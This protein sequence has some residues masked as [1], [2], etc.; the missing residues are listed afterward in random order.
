MA[1][2]AIAGGTGGVGRTILEELIRQK[3]H[4]VVVLSRKVCLSNAAQLTAYRS[5][6]RTQDTQIKGYESV[7]VLA[8]DYSDVDSTAA[9]LQK[10]NIGTIISALSLFTEEVGEAQMRL[11]QAAINSNVVKRFV[12]SEFAFNYLR[13]GLRDFHDAAQMRMDAAD[14]L[15]DSHVEFTRFVFGWILD[16]WNPVSAKTNMPPMTWVVDFPN[17]KARI[18]GDGTKSITVMH[19]HDIGKYIAALL[20]EEKA[21][22]EMSAFAGDKVS[23]NEMV[24]MAER[25]TGMMVPA[26]NTIEVADA[27]M[28]GQKFEV[29]FEPIERLEKKE[30]EVLEQPEGSYDFGEGL[31]QVT[32]E[33]GLMVVK[34]MMDASIDGLRNDEFPGVKPIKMEAWMR[35]VWG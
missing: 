13:P 7:P 24:E 19:S 9:T 10:H 6:T 22:P 2:V 34:G 28:T 20:D 11:I 26:C 17:R 4:D 23:F 5:L 14:K 3:K 31:A 8:V 30:V 12:P 35:D 25:V 29:S 1:K 27:R 21:W 18:P 33:F 16:T 32:A 15:R